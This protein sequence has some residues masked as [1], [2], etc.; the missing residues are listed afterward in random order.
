MAQKQQNDA[1]LVI[2]NQ[3]NADRPQTK[4]VKQR[5]AATAQGSRPQYFDQEA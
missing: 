5:Q 2:N 4:Q 3:Q 1:I